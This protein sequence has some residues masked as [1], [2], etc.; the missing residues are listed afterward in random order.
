MAMNSG[1]R[2][3]DERGKCHTMIFCLSFLEFVS[4]QDVLSSAFFVLSR[5]WASSLVVR[6]L[7]FRALSLFNID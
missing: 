2:G 3:R 7:V 6:F 5:R 4:S 1:D